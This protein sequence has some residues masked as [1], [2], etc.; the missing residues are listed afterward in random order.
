MNKFD[1][2]TRN[3]LSETVNLHAENFFMVSTDFRDTS[4]I[5]PILPDCRTKI[6]HPLQDFGK[7]R[8]IVSAKRFICVVSESGISFF[9]SDVPSTA[10]MDS[11]AFIQSKKGSTPLSQTVSARPILSI[12][13]N[14]IVDM[15][16]S[17]CGR[18]LFVFGG[19]GIATVDLMKDSPSIST[20]LMKGKISRGVCA[21]KERSRGVLLWTEK[22]NPRKL[23]FASFAINDEGLCLDS[24]NVFDTEAS[25]SKSSD[26]VMGFADGMLGVVSG[27]E[28][29]S[30]YRLES[31]GVS[32]GTASLGSGL[33]LQNGEILAVIPVSGSRVLPNL[34]STY[35][36]VVVVQADVIT[37]FSSVTENGTEKLDL[38]FQFRDSISKRA[39]FSASVDSQKPWMVCV[40]T[41]AFNN[42]VHLEMFDLSLLKPK[43]VSLTPLMR[44]DVSRL[45]NRKEGHDMIVAFVQTLSDMPSFVQSVVDDAT[46]HRLA[47]VWESV[48]KDQ[49][50]SFMPNFKVLNKN[51]PYVEAEEEFDFNQDAD[52]DTVCS[53]LNRYKKADKRLF[54]FV[55]NPRNERKSKDKCDDVDMRDDTVV[56][57]DFFIPFL[58]PLDSWKGVRGD[59]VAQEVVGKHAEFFGP[60][61][62]RILADVI[63]NRL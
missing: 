18:F 37:V 56:D 8:R 47:I 62:A 63:K 15:A 14:D 29:V 4:T 46:G 11:S 5:G 58:A 61:C 44:F 33:S 23:N 38:V 26:L 57:D 24:K 43:S 12:P 39:F 45:F 30:L 25:S 19:D 55:P 48:V 7:I 41:E 42:R 6:L 34:M 49:W 9:P 13:C 3:S 22:S 60:E 35:G 53:T 31:D 17:K 1:I 59:D 32:F 28:K 51:L 10:I 54:D 52:M 40:S 2:Y 16:V 27:G 36:G 50:Y 20:P 21:Q